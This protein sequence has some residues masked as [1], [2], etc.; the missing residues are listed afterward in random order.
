MPPTPEEI[1]AFLA[2]DSPKA[3]EK[4]VDRLLASPAYGERWGR[5]WLDVAHY[6]DTA[7]ET[8][9]YPV[10]QA[11]RYRNYVIDSFN[12][13]KPYDQFV[14]EQIAGD[15]LTGPADKAGAPDRHR[16]PRRRPPFRL[17]PAE[18]PLS[19]HR[20]HHRH[21]G[22]SDSRPDRRLRPLPRSQV[23]SHIPGRLLCTL[24]DI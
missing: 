21:D 7:G 2:D 1:D 11:Y 5:Y 13:D 10:P 16:L 15:L 19:H 3:F 17:R 14:R 23:R 9:D 24:W 22:Q 12:A 20:R 6:A 8:A 4:V 18:L